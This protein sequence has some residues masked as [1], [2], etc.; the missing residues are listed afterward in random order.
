MFGLFTRK[1]KKPFYW[2]VKQDEFWFRPSGLLID[3]NEHPLA[4]IE[5]PFQLNQLTTTHDGFF[6]LNW[7][8]LFES[9]S[10]SPETQKR[11]FDKPELF[12]YFQGYWL[13][14]L[15]AQLDQ[16]YSL[17][18]SENFIL[19]STK[20]EKQLKLTFSFLESAYQRIINILDGIVKPRQGNK[21]AVIL[22][23][24]LDQYYQYISYYYPKDGEYQMSSGCFLSEG[25]G[26]FA[27][28]DSDI[29]NLESVI[30][31]ELTHALVSHLEIPLWVNE[32]LAVNT[33]ITVTGY[34]PYL[35]NS[36]RHKKHTNYWNDKTIQEFWFGRSFSK[37]GEA[38]ELSYQ[39]AQLLVRSL[40][41]D[42]ESF[43]RFVNFSKYQDAGEAAAIEFFGGSLGE[44]IES[45]YGEGEWT[46]TK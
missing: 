19:L 29:S 32:G 3:S 1:E 21:L 23:E 31:H 14:Q 34:S 2:P 44:L 28:P 46:P 33:E 45:I 10:Q 13:N 22:F 25:L 6:R 17:N 15:N 30:A 26:H 37:P 39:L 27:L 35:L 18:Q 20:N 11:N 24:D 42:F 5:L 7:K 38:S 36:E 40:S 8:F 43:C 12:N 41:E 4:N 16:N 9:Y